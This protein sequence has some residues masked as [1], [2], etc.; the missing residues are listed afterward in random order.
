MVI[1]GWR[2]QMSLDVHGY[3]IQFSINQPPN[4]IDGDGIL[5]DVDDDVDGDGIINADDD[6]ID[7]DGIL[8]EYD[9]D[10]DGDGIDN[11]SDDSQSGYFFYFLLIHLDHYNYFLTLQKNLVLSSPTL[12][13]N[14]K[15]LVVL[16]SNGEIVYRN[17]LMLNLTSSEPYLFNI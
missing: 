9:D 16:N 4:D 3:L 7:G 10:I 6:D 14:F 5:N 8:N 13:S 17:N 1:F 11:D 12:K 15:G 2:Q